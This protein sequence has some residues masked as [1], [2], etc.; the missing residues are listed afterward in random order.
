MPYPFVAGNALPAAD[1]NAA[2]A[3]RATL[4]G[5]ETLTN[6][7]ISGAT[8]TGTTTLPSSGQINSS[9]W[10]GI[11]GTTAAQVDIRGNASAA[12]WGGNGIGLRA[13][14]NTY[15]DT[16]STGTVANLSIHTLSGGTVAAS[17]VTTFTAAST[18]RIAAA[19]TAGSNVTLTNAYAIHVVAGVSRFDAAVIAMGNTAIPAGGTAGSGFRVSSTANFGV[20]FGS[21]APTLSAA[22]GS[23]YLRSDGTTTND[24][25]Y[26]NTNGTTTW[27]ALT[28]AA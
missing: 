3:A 28:T 23:L 14:A 10:I 2:F 11:G 9:G 18:L 6:K 20:F 21:G 24:R 4:T 26:I 22:K 5:S 7:T 17:S 25:A 1:L 15:T 27:T 19:P 16:S 8:L 13:R 12:Q